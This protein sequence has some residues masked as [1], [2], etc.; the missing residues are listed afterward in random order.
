ME[1]GAL[2]RTSDQ[3]GERNVGLTGDSISRQGVWSAVR[4][5]RRAVPIGQGLWGRGQAVVWLLA[6]GTG[7]L[8]LIWAAA[9]L[10]LEEVQFAVVAPEAL[11]GVEAAS[12]LARLF[13]ALVLFL[14]PEGARQAGQPAGTERLRWVA[15][16]LLALGLG[17]LTFG[18][19]HPLLVGPPDPS[20]A[21]YASTAVWS[22]AGALFVVGLV[23]DRPRRFSPGGAVACLA[24]CGI[25][26]AILLGFGEALPRLVPAG[27]LELAAA[28]AETPLHGLTGWYWA[29][30]SVPLA[31]TVA[32]ACGAGRR[33]ARGEAGGW[34]LLALVLL[35]AS[36]VH[37]LFW[38]A[39]YSRV[40][41]TGNLLR[42]AFA[43]VVAVGGILE[44][45]RAAAERAAL[46]AAE[47]ECSRRLRE[48][49]VLKADFT[50]MVAHELGSP[51]A[52]IRGLAA[53]LATGELGREE[54]ARTIA[55]IQ[56]EAGMLAALVADVQAIATIE[57]DEFAVRPRPVPL[58]VLLADAAAFA[59]TLPGGHPLRLEYSAGGR[60]LA[61]PERIGQVLRNLL[62]NAA[63]YSP[64]GAPIELRACPAGRGV[65]I[66]VTDHGWGI[67]PDDLPH[68]FEKF[69]RGRTGRGRATPGLGL[70]LYLSRRIVQAHGS[71]LHVC[72]TPGQGST[73]SFEL[74]DVQ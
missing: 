4:G 22:T 18:Y 49:A 57:H 28:T 46:L 64:E 9:I 23:P 63:K 15:A 61:D 37:N 43:A 51:L 2:I 17:T 3:A 27:S 20:S 30:A 24:C 11:A 72:S 58:E 38:P 36:Q 39:A 70:G 25:L 34:L 29:L 66:E 42:L 6:V 62:G 45:R 68:I 8:T 26:G 5:L 13:G 31:L 21:V 12:A 10:L 1:A 7:V 41:T 44:L 53:M 55:A 54:Q 48:L 65:R 40:L 50:A 33:V 59:H 73:F 47:Q 67:H 52:A 32:A 14:F 69:G 19:T 60:V 71:E 35:A 56:A 74:E 16:G